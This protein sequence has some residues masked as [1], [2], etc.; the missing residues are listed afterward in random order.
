MHYPGRIHNGQNVE[1]YVWIRYFYQYP[2]LSILWWKCLCGVNS[3]EQ[4]FSTKNSK[5][6]KTFLLTYKM[7]TFIYFIK[8]KYFNLHRV[9]PHSLDTN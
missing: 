8:E 1:C 9:L 5:E 7:H 4:G 3:T 2:S 6:N